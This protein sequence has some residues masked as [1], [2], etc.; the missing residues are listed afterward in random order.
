MQF[1]DLLLGF[2]HQTSVLVGRLGED[3]LVGGGNIDFL[4]GGPEHFNPN[5][6]DKAFGGFG[7]DVF[8]WAPGDGSDRFD[9]GPGEDTII[10]GLIGEDDGSGN[11]SFGVSNDQLAGDVFLDFFGLPMVDVTNSPGFCNVIDDSTSASA[12]AD[13]SN[14]GVDH[15]VQFFIRGINN[16]FVNGVQNTD[17]GLRVTLHL[18]DVEYLVCTDPNGGAIV[19]F[20]L[21]TSPPTPIAISS[22]PF[23]VQFIIQ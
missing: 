19:A 1:H 10:F 21:R 20:D 7:D 16:A 4:I 5:N 18:K 11:P 12:A 9:G 8:I 13:L 14:I 15:L 22:L 3:I 2:S 6:R 17:N 23:A